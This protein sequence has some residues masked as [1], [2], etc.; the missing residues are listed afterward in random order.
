MGNGAKEVYESLQKVIKTKNA[1]IQLAMT[2]CFGFCSE[3]TL[4]NCYI[5]GMPLVILHKVSPKDADNI[6]NPNAAPP[7]GRT[8]SQW[9]DTSAVIPI[10]AL[11]SP[12]NITE[13]NL[14]L[15]SNMAPPARSLDFSVF[16]DFPFT[17]KY[18]L[19]FRAEGTNVFNTPQFGTPDNG[20][21]V[22]EG[23]IHFDGD[24]GA[25]QELEAV[26][27]ELEGAL[28]IL[29]VQVR[30]RAAAP[31]QLE[32]LAAILQVGADEIQFLRHRG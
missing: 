17:E 9:F 8:P 15:Q 20:A 12:S 32:S 24:L 31:V 4:V 21:S 13:G 25:R 10:G 23:G 28:E 18:K 27:E 7:G 16:K 26:F 6:V 3:E 1:A 29:R 14:G 22:Q 11:P 19:Q 2:G 5:P 30:G